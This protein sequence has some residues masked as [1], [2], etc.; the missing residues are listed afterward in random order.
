MLKCN[1]SRPCFGKTDKGEC[2]ILTSSC[3]KD[4]KCK[5]CKSRRKWTNGNY[6]PDREEVEK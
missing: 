5:F 6:Y 4:G 1:D 2:T 3:M